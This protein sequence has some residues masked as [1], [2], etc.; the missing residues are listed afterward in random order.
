M[1]SDLLN[2][3]KLLK[4]NYLYYISI[5]FICLAFGF[6]TK[7]RLLYSDPYTELFLGDPYDSKVHNLVRTFNSYILHLNQKHLI[8]I[9]T[10]E[11]H[12][13]LFSKTFSINYVKEVLQNPQVLYQFVDQIKD[14]LDVSNLKIK[15]IS[16]ADYNEYTIKIS[17]KIENYELSKKIINELFNFINQKIISDFYDNYS[18]NLDTD[19]FNSIIINDLKKYNL[20]LQK[21]LQE[22]E[23][24]DIK[25][26]RYSQIYDSNSKTLSF[27]PIAF[28]FLGIFV[29]L[30]I[31]IIINIIYKDIKN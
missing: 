29:S 2:Y 7:E 11:H 14:Q 15:N 17:L 18:M 23:V 16:V 21:D 25:K 9:P 24:Y 20:L 26:F 8:S 22:I 10:I 30:V 3:F 5:I 12:D 1:E 19:L 27:L 6:F 31:N 28:L 13:T 4:K